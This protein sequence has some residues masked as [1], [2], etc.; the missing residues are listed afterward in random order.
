MTFLKEK[1]ASL[2]PEREITSLL[3]HVEIRRSLAARPEH[4]GEELSMFWVPGMAVNNLSNS[5]AHV[6]LCYCKGPPYVVSSTCM[7]LGGFSDRF[8]ASQDWKK[9]GPTGSHNNNVNN[10]IHLQRELFMNIQASEG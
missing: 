2:V 10:N 1:R 4:L 5:A 8:V 3:L 7:K 9:K 6:L